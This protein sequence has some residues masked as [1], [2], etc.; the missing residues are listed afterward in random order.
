MNAEAGACAEVMERSDMGEDNRRGTTDAKVGKRLGNW[1]SAVAEG[2]RCE[3]Y[4]SSTG[5]CDRKGQ[6]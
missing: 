5:R 4:V 6:G 3:D 1:Y 2:G